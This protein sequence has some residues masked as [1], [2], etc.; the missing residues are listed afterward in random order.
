MK[1]AIFKAYKKN[2]WTFYSLI[3][4]FIAIMIAIIGYLF[5]DKLKSITTLNLIITCMIIMWIGFIL[6][7]I[8]IR[9]QNK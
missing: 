6:L 3:I 1:L 7:R 8:G 4:Q 5:I 9:K 2:K